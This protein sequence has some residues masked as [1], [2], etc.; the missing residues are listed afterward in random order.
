MDLSL[1]ER[2]ILSITPF[3]S[4]LTSFS[5]ILWKYRYPRG[6][7][8]RYEDNG[9]YWYVYRVNKNCRSVKRIRW[10]REI[11]VFLHMA[12]VYIYF[13]RKLEQ[14]CFSKMQWRINWFYQLIGSVG[15][16]L[17]STWSISPSD[18]HNG[19]YNTSASMIR[20]EMSLEGHCKAY[21]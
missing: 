1:W 16:I 14:S 9:W 5:L 11:R 7:S 12:D 10:E 2:I 6:L 20:N 8:W 19:E 17:L 21:D 18:N 4:L 15:K 13:F 3:V